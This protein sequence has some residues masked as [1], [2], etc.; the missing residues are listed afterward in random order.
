[1]T[2]IYSWMHEVDGYRDV[3]A[4]DEPTY[5]DLLIEMHA[6]SLREVAHV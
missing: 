4:T 5:D 6:A 2:P 1:V 3:L